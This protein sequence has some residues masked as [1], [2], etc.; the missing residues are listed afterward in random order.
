VNIAVGNR[1]NIQVFNRGYATSGAVQFPLSPASQQVLLHSYGV[2]NANSAVCDV[3]L[4]ISL[5]SAESFFYTL[6]SGLAV[7]QKVQSASAVTLFT[8]SNNDGIL[9][10]AKVPFG[11]IIVNLSQAQTGSPVYAYQYWNGVSWAALT[12]TTTTSYSSTGFAY[13]TFKAPADWVTGDNGYTSNNYYSIRVLATTAPSQAVQGSGVVV[14][15]WISYQEQLAAGARL[16]VT[17]NMRPILLE[18]SE[19]L[20]PFFGSAFV[21]NA[22]EASYQAAQ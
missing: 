2:Y 21:Q 16:Q 11:Y 12:T 6:V 14:A 5:S 1:N 10:E 17:F 4:G 15:K 19:S 8:T 13:I 18:G 22:V 7:A 3:G 9:I 20:A